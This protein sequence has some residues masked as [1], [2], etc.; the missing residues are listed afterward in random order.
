MS[1]IY[2]KKDESWLENQLF[3]YFFKKNMSKIYVFYIEDFVKKW[4]NIIVTRI[5]EKIKT[6]YAKTCEI[7]V[8]CK[9]S[10]R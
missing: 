3:L 5:R 7:P 8:C 1:Q 9:E 6:F 10:C 2:I 4:Y